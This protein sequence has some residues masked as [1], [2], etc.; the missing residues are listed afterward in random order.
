[1]MYDREGRQKL[2]FLIFFDQ[3]GKMA[4]TENKKSD[5]P[6]AQNSKKDVFALIRGKYKVYPDLPLAELDMPNAKAFQAEDVANPEHKVFALICNPDLPVRKDHI[7]NRIGLKSEGLLPLEEAGVAFWPL[8]D[9]KTMVLIYN[10]PL[11]GRVVISKEYGQI[12]PNEESEKIS[13][14]IRPLLAGIA[15]LAMRG[16]THRA[17]RPDNLFFMDVEK[18][19]VVLGDCISV[20]AGYDQPSVYETIETSMCQIEGKGK[21]TVADDLYAFGATLVC[22]GL[23]YNPLEHISDKDLLNLKIQKGSYATLI[24]EGRVPLALIELYRGLLA[25]DVSLRWDASAV[26]LWADGRRLT[27]IQAKMAKVSQ[28]PLIFNDVEYYSYRTLAYAFSNHWEKAA[29][30]IRS[31]KLLNWIDRG[32]DDKNTVKAIKKSIDMA[33]LRF[34]TKEKQDDFIVARTCM[35]L[36]PYAPLRVRECSFQPDALGTMLAMNMDDPQKLKFLISM[37]TTGYMESWCEFH[38]DLSIEQEI[39][40][41]QLTLQKPGLG[42][43][44]ERVLYDLNESLPCRSPLIVKEYVY[45]MKDVLP[46]LDDNIK[47]SNMKTEALDRHVCAFIAS[48]YGKKTSDDILALNSLKENQIVLGALHLLS[49]LQKDFGPEHLYNLTS[50]AGSLVGPVIDTYHN[51]EKRRQLEKNL[52]KIIRKGVFKDLISFLDDKQ[53]KIND[54]L[55]FEQAKK[56]YAKLSEEIDFLSGNRAKREEEGKMLGYQAVAVIS[57]GIALITMFFLMLMQVMRG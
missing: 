36:D 41:L 9:R 6:V 7:K 34:S 31:D 52:S 20:P 35:L 24:G 27:P 32:F 17:I 23:G 13:K 25:D 55:L 14:W 29:E 2:S 26:T 18:T 4:D 5:A 33:Q 39:K 42:M 21:G 51:V 48:R 47:K 22:L 10:Q 40:K 50:W 57:F 54:A 56:E 53:E 37:I 43:G 12:L 49:V 8:I 28:R 44:V 15:D 1:M 16:L 11:G 3:K 46:A 30:M 19:K 38:K 45:E